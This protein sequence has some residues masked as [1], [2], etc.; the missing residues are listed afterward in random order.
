MSF[1]KT[2]SSDILKIHD[3]ESFIEGI[4][5]KLK[6]DIV[7]NIRKQGGVIGI[8]GGIDSSVTFALAVKALGAGR[9]LGVMLPEKDSSADSK[10]FAL[11][12][13][14][15]F[16]AEAI[17]ENITGALEGFNCYKRR[18]EAVARSTLR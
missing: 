14:N 8:S 15:K 16:S 9:V 11:Q 17:D 7:S 18:D 1:K 2:F 5:V 13:A 3:I 6:N 12:L 4:T 10:E